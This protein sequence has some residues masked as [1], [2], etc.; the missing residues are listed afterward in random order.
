MGAR[1]FGERAIETSV[2]RFRATLCV[3]IVVMGFKCGFPSGVGVGAVIC[4]LLL[5]P[6]SVPLRIE[7]DRVRFFSWIRPVSL[8]VEAVCFGL[9]SCFELLNEPRLRVTV[10]DS[11]SMRV[12]SVRSCVPKYSEAWV[13]V[14]ELREELGK[15][16]PYLLTCSKSDR[17]MH[18]YCRSFDQMVSGGSAFRVAVGRG[19]FRKTAAAYV[20]G[21]ETLESGNLEITSSL[22]KSRIGDFWVVQ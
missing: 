7:E 1:R 2:G 13:L 22:E 4:Y 12:Y 15:G 6:I 21:V 5:V 19:P 11:R 20:S 3:A 17:R 10:L 16:V 9:E 8:P 14:S 18:S